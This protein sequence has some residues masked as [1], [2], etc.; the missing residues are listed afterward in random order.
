M[1]ALL[2]ESVFFWSVCVAFAAIFSFVLGK[3]TNRKSLLFLG[4]TAT[5]ATALL[6][7]FCDFCVE[8]DRKAVRRMTPAVLRL[9]A[10]SSG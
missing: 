1:L 9:R 4:L 7:A 3:A 6:G 8:T 5:L 2:T 10:Q